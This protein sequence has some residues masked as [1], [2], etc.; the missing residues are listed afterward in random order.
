LKYFVD[1]GK[2]LTGNTKKILL[3]NFLTILKT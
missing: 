3:S 1:R 2:I